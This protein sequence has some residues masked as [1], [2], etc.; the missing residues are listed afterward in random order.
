MNMHGHMFPPVWLIII[1]LHCNSERIL[2]SLPGMLLGGL[3]K[4][5]RAILWGCG[6]RKVA[7]ATLRLCE[8]LP[9]MRDFLDFKM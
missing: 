1:F 4:T 9:L 3:T 6:I 7:F 2:S 5:L 8:R